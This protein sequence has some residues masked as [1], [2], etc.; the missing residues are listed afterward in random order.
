MD[1]R[2]ARPEFMGG[3]DHGSDTGTP[4][5]HAPEARRR[6]R[7]MAPQDAGTDTG[8]VTLTVI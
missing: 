1:R 4:Q 3:R 6:I 2:I 8:I 5:G 7:D